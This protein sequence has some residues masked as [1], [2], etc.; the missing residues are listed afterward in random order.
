MTNEVKVHDNALEYASKFGVCF[1][2]P[3]HEA[4]FVLAVMDG[5]G[6]Q[7]ILGIT[8]EL[9]SSKKANKKWHNKWS[10]LIHPD[11]LKEYPELAEISQIAS[12][13]LNELYTRMKKNAK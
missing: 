8:N 5:E 3:I 6:R 10:R 4:C 9:Y 13:K 12:S 2:S 11:R 7:N 1:K